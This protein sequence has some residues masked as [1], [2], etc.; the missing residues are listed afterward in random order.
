M[1]KLRAPV[2]WADAMTR[3]AGTLT[4]AGARKIVTR[5]DSLVRK[6]SDASTG[7]LPTIEQA[8]RLDTAHRAHGGEGAPFFDTYAALLEIRVSQAMA[9]RIALAEDLAG[10]ARD[11]GDVISTAIAVTL[12]GATDRDVLRALAETEEAYSRTGRLLRRLKSFLPTSTGLR[13]GIAGG[14]Q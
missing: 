3:V 5:S 7:K 8:L 11:Y 12:P 2:T 6:W 4:F 9:C 1:T 10:A 14:L 13:A